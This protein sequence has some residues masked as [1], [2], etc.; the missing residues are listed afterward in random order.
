M[1]T[2]DEILALLCS[3]YQDHH[4]SIVS[5]YTTNSSS[6]SSTSAPTT[7]GKLDLYTNLYH[8]SQVLVLGQTTSPWNFLFHLERLE[9][10]R[11]LSDAKGGIEA[12]N[13]LRTRHVQLES[14]SYLLLPLLY[15][16]GYFVEAHAQ[17]KLILHFHASVQYDTGEQ[18]G[19]AFQFSNYMKCMEMFRFI[20][21]CKRYI[22]VYMVC[23]CIYEVYVKCMCRVCMCIY[24]YM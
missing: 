19:K 12:F 3:A 5:R 21:L 14:M 2:G 24:M 8:W 10:C 23:M 4:R 15:E 17:L 11:S 6:T 1:Q 13:K 18:V 9:T 7:Q 22:F 20:A 16:Y